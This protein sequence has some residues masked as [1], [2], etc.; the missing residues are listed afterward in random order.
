[1]AQAM[2]DERPGITVFGTDWCE[3]TRRTRRLLRR[4]A[5]RHRYANVDEDL[6]A[7]ERA[8][9]LAHGSRRT[10][11]VEIDGQT[12]VEPTNDVLTT[13]LVGS[14]RL[15]A[16]R[17]R[18]LMAVQ[19]VGDAERLLRVVAGLCLYAGTRR[20]PAPLRLVANLTALGFVLT[21]VSGWCPGYGAAEVSSIGGPG[22][23]PAEA[24]RREW[25]THAAP[26]PPVPSEP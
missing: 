5:I 21:G 10:P 23:R 3:D 14:E 17:A 16:E 12:L 11:I 2:T 24:E 20:L 6:A 25:L 7:L 1:M 19:N 18:E 13:A 9:A 22:D 8:V 15:T 26:V 4:L